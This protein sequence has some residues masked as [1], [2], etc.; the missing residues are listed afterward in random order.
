MPRR[1]GAAGVPRS[2]RPVIRL[3]GCRRLRVRRGAGAS[4]VPGTERP[5]R[6]DG[7]RRGPCLDAALSP[8]R[9]ACQ[10]AGHPF[11]SGGCRARSAGNRIPS[12]AG[13]T[14]GS[15]LRLPGERRGPRVDALPSPHRPG[16]RRR[17]TPEMAQRRRGG[18]PWEPA[19]PSHRLTCVDQRSAVVMGTAPSSASWTGARKGP[20]AAAAR[21]SSP[22][23]ALRSMVLTS[24]P[25]A[26]SAWY[27]PSVWMAL[28]L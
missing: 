6:R 5:G 20:R 28:R 22:R 17:R 25:A 11:D 18:L 27:T 14:E 23:T 24:Y 26:I 19:P 13:M 16:P 15:H 3:P 2:S 9:S 8:H 7:E 10:V 4:R 1:C 21:R 12:F